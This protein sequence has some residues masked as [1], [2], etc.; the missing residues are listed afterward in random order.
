MEKT[1]TIS[2]EFKTSSISSQPTY[3]EKTIIGEFVW[4]LI[5]CKSDEFLG[6]YLQC[7]PLQS[8][9]EWMCITSFFLSEKSS[10]IT[11]EG[12]CK[13][14][15]KNY[16]GIG[17]PEF[18][19]W[20]DL[21]G[22]ETFTLEAEI[23]IKDSYLGPPI[24]TE[25]K[26][27][28]VIFHR[29]AQY[30]FPKQTTRHY[31]NDSIWI[32]EGQSWNGVLKFVVNKFNK[33]GKLESNLPSGAVV[34]TVQGP[35]II[36]TKSGDLGTTITLVNWIGEETQ[37]VV[38]FLIHDQPFLHEP[39]T[40]K[41]F[42]FGRQ[43][44][45]LPAYGVFSLKDNSTIHLNPYVIVENSP[46]LKSIIETEGTLD[47]DVSD[48]DPN[49]VRIFVDAC[50]TGALE[51]LS[52][53]TEFEVFSDFVKM[54]AVFKIDW[55]KKGITEYFEKHLPEPL[56]DFCAYWDYAVLA[57]DYT[58]NYADWSLLGCLLSCKPQNKIKFQFHL[59][60][61]VTVIT[62]RSHLDLLMAMLV[63]FHLVDEFMKQILILL[64][65][66]NKIPLLNYWLQNFNFSLCD[67]ETLTLL[68]EAL[69]PIISPE[70][71][72]QLMTAVIDEKSS[73]T[74]EDREEEDRL[75]T[76][77][78]LIPSDGTLATVARNHWAKIVS[79]A[80]PCSKE[81]PFSLVKRNLGENV[82]EKNDTSD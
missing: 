5:V 81:R 13:Y 15:K 27:N 40:P 29:Q 16:E 56:E 36:E 52:D 65:V 70:A 82:E 67:K 68:T 60:P 79:S 12:R 31:A 57:L 46:V 63:E 8:S 33:E 26:A 38:T 10:G 34:I 55:A 32:T 59:F 47:H 7:E 58:I 24:V 51:M 3:S 17:S 20:K 76:T 72:C 41:G 62:K 71:C 28:V 53:T 4:H 35:T 11:K 77:I 2:V 78:Q 9:N 14:S 66:G 75:M 39:K 25:T 49:S 30:F 64:M 19:A 73:K 37:A 69:E 61:L 45:S 50:Y 1:T 80:W 42:D 22:K 43:Y 21:D 6:A 74:D 18:M 54:V 48:F 44:L 23:T